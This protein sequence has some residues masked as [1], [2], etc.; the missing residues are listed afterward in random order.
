MVFR[1]L[2]DAALASALWACA[3]TRFETALSAADRTA[4]AAA[5]QVALESSRTGEGRIWEA[6]QSGH[7]G[8]VTPLRTW[9]D[10]DGQPCR[11]YQ[12]LVTIDGA[13]RAATAGACRDPSGLWRDIRPPRRYARPDYAHDR[14]SRVHLSFGHH[15]G[16]HP[17]PINLRVH[18]HSAGLCG[19][20]QFRYRS[21]SDV[22]V[23]ATEEG[24]IS[25]VP[26]ARSV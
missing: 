22:A 17:V 26:F 24:L 12:S 18:V 7:R 19:D 25:G 15:V 8:T 23:V 14:G 6:P 20:R 13:T 10:D 5:V 1:A 21:A 4:M 3:P 2:T 16:Y 9:H 11:D